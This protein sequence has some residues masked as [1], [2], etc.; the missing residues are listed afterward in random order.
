MQNNI[1]ST[2]DNYHGYIGYRNAT[3]ISKLVDDATMNTVIDNWN[4]TAPQIDQNAE[5]TTVCNLD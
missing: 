4:H 1:I 2:G 3:Y 5:E